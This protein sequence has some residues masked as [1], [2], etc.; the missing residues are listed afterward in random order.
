[1]ILLLDCWKVHKS[2]DFMSW[3]AET[4]PN[5]KLL[6]IPADCT[7]KAQPADVIMQRP[8]KCGFRQEFDEYISGEVSRHLANGQSVLDIKLDFGINNLRERSVEWLRASWRGLRNKLELIKEGWE[9]CGLLQPWDP[10]EQAKA[11]QLAADGVLFKDAIPTMEKPE[12]PVDDVEEYGQEM[13]GGCTAATA[14]P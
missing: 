10:E 1:V 3:L 8:L 13:E 6:F 5:I 11:M 14:A 7:S 12:L 2:Q 9:Q 4:Y